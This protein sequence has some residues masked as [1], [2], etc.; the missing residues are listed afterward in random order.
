M[1]SVAKTLGQLKWLWFARPKRPL[2]DFVAFDEPS[3]GPWGSLLLSIKRRLIHWVSLGALIVIATQAFQPIIQQYH[4]FNTM[5]A[6]LRSILQGR[7]EIDGDIPIYGSDAIEI[8]VDTLLVE[9]Y[10]EAA[11]ANFL[12]GL[13]TSMTNTLR[14]GS[15]SEAVNGT[16]YSLV[17]YVKVDWPW[18]VLP[19]TLVLLSFPFLVVTILQSSRAKIKPWKT[20]TMATLQ[21]LGVEL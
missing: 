10:D 19:A 9:P 12:S 8:L 14:T 1:G 11:M 4:C 17:S 18:L 2:M 7:Y 16:S 21:G 20:S 13:A 6:F 3:K 5:N 15:W